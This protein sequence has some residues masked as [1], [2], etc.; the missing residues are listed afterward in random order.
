[1]PSASGKPASIAGGTA[2]KPPAGVCNTPRQAGH[3]GSAAAAAAA[4][5]TPLVAFVWSVRGTVIGAV[6][7]AVDEV[8][9]EARAAGCCSAGFARKSLSEGVVGDDAAS[10][11]R[12]SSGLSA[13]GAAEGSACSGY[14][15]IACSAGN[16]GGCAAAAVP[17]SQRNHTKRV[18]T[19]LLP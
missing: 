17:V 13:A 4:A 7:G 5:P 9:S 19:L 11:V 8:S 18:S 15:A 6:V 14:G 12:A 10:T 3:T 16:E 2:C 1:M